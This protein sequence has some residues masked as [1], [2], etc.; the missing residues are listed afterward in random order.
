MPLITLENSLAEVYEEL[1]QEIKRAT[2]DKKHPFRYVVLSTSGVHVRS[3]YV[4]LRALTEEQEMVIYTDNRSQKIED[5]HENDRVQL[6]FYHAGKQVQ[7]IVSGQVNIHANDEMAQSHWE[8]VKGNAQR[9]YNTEA[10]PGK[11]IQHPEQGH[12]WKEQ[13]DDEHFAVLTI[14]PIEMEILQ[15]NRSEHLRATFKS[16]NDWQGNWLVP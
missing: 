5:I 9:A 10:A 12:R 13:M 16:E 8:K 1:I 14:Q 15:L 7:L 6:L 11:E 3:R 4:V 2:V